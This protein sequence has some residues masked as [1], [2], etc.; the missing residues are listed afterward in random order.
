MILHDYT[1]TWADEFERLK[2]VYAD[3]L[4][5]LALAI[6]HVGSTSITGIKAKPIID[7]DVVIK[8]YTIF[9]DVVER[10]AQLGYTHNG[11]QGVLHR[12]AF[13][14]QDGFTPHTTPQRQWMLHHLYVCPA[15]SEELRR[16]LLFR[17]YLRANADARNAYERIKVVIAARSDGDRKVYAAIKE[18]E[19]GEFFERTLTEARKTCQVSK[20]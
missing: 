20:T 5:D 13:K 2:H 19:Y 12:E 8:D 15:F 6:E 11:D 3:A 16:H 10:L 14:Y 7:I 4:G 9:P 18:A 17:D 1:P